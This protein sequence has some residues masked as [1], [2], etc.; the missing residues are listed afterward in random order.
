VKPVE[1]SE[2]ERRFVEEVG[3]HVESFALPRIAGRTFGLM[4]VAPRPL[5]LEEIADLLQVSR[6]SV[7]INTRIGIAT[8]VIELRTVPGDRRKF[9]VF[10][11]RAW[12]SRVE[13][14]LRHLTGV[15][16]IVGE[17]L[18][19]LSPE[20][21]VARERLELAQQLVAVLYQKAQELAPIVLGHIH[22]RSLR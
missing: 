22:Q 15:R 14:L 7:S 4:L 16:R 1:L 5:A 8:G 12:E 11:E 9:Y 2:G 13:L 3:Q 20:N 21:T 17:G 19:G 6:A 10:A 18:R